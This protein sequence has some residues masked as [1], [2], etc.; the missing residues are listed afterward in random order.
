M[1]YILFVS[2]IV[3]SFPARSQQKIL[4]GDSILLLMEHKS[5]DDLVKNVIQE[6]NL[7]L[8]YKR[9]YQNDA[10]GFEVDVDT[11][12][13]VNAIIWFAKLEKPQSNPDTFITKQFPFQLPFNLTM[14]MSKGEIMQA[15]AKQQYNVTDNK[16]YLYFEKGRLQVSVFLRKDS[17]ISTIQV[18]KKIR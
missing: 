3:L 4:Q 8:F 18:L 17:G 6:Y 12:D 13:S 11:Q 1:R 10:M 15:L 5:G 14:N 9:Q 16:Y 2:L 7:K